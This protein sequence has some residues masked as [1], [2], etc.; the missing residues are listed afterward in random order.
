MTS[1]SELTSM[2]DF[3]LAGGTALALLT[4]HRISID[5]DFFT[6][7][8]PDTDFILEQLES[9]SE[10]EVLLHRKNSTLLLQIRGVKVDIIRHAYPVLDPIISEAPI[11]LYG[12]RDIAA[13]KLNALASRGAKKDF[14]DLFFLMKQFSLEELLQAFCS[15]YQQHEIQFILKSLLYFDDADK[16]VDP[17]M[18][19][20]V[21]WPSV[22][23]EISRQVLLYL[24]S[25][26]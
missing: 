19:T 12:L 23:A 14:I 11:R 7:T 4:G 16:E 1:L 26:L 8:T 6:N 21:P 2:Q 3:A 17:V 24:K 22:K 13:M 25:T 18:I 10:K 9:W 5:L 15:K 20:P